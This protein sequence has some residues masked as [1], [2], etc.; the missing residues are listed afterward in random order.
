MGSE[1][2]LTEKINFRVSETVYKKLMTYLE[3]TQQ[4][5]S[6]MM[7]EAT[8]DFLRLKKVFEENGYVKKEKK[9]KKANPN[10][11]SPAVMFC[12]GDR[13]EIDPRKKR[14]VK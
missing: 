13:C 6:K 2:N 14:S 9:R 8:Y 3:E 12:D 5:I 10:V 1:E 11:P 7:R 4:T